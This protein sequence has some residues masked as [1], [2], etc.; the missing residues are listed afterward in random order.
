MS[1]DIENFRSK[2]FDLLQ[3]I[4]VFILV[5]LAN[6][7]ICGCVGGLVLVQLIASGYNKYLSLGAAILIAGG[8]HY[9]IW[10]NHKIRNFI[11]IRSQ[12]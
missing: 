7:F 5:T 6:V 3:V 9:Y 2:W 10:C 11:K 1:D 4:P 12:K 8:T